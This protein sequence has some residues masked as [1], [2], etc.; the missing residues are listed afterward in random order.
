MMAL[1]QMGKGFF[2]LATFIVISILLLVIT[3]MLLRPMEYS[4]SCSA[5]GVSIG[6][7]NETNF[8]GFSLND[9]EIKCDISGEVPLI[10][11]LGELG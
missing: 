7:D 8:T 11:I 4:V 5:D 3:V 9:S 10:F 1:S 2:V 6:I